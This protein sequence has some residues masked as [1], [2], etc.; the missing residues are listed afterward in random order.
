MSPNEAKGLKVC[1]GKL[2]W[3]L[4]PD[5][6]L[7]ECIKGLM[8]GNLK[9]ERDN[10][11]L[12]DGEVQRDYRNAAKRHIAADKAGEV[13]IPDPK[14]DIEVRHLASAINSLMIMMWHQMKEEKSNSEV[15]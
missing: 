12:Q 1:Q 3:E 7:K 8:D 9:Y 11:K 4:L 15:A 5:E 14:G 13:Y 6:V 10:W 2:D